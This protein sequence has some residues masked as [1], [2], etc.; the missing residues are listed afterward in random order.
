ME[1]GDLNGK[2]NETP[3]SNTD[4]DIFELLQKHDHSDVLRTIE[5]S[6]LQLLMEPDVE[7]L[8]GAGRH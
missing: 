1:F 6:V 3:M 2:P 8:I 4:I 5:E 7:G